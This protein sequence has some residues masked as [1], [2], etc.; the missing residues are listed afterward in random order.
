MTLQTASPVR[1]T[2]VAHDNV[3]CTVTMRTPFIRTRDAAWTSAPVGVWSVRAEA[4]FHDFSVVPIDDWETEPEVVAVATV[5]AHVID[6]FRHPS[7]FRALDPIDQEKASMGERIDD[8]IDDLYDPVERVILI[9]RLEVDE[10]YRGQRLGPHLLTTLIDSVGGRGDLVVLHAMPLQWR[11]LSPEE[12][13]D[14]KVK[15]RAVYES[16]GFSTSGDDIFWHHT[17]QREL[18]V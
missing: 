17:A 16:M 5:E 1:S 10:R 12:L 9:D 2:Q 15:V 3:E 8:I 18:R 13:D 11:D 7:V 4:N 6:T 14:A